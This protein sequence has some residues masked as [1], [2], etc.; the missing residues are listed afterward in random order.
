VSVIIAGEVETSNSRL[1]SHEW[2]KRVYRGLEVGLSSVTRLNRFR[3]LCG[4]DGYPNLLEP[5]AFPFAL[6]AGR[7]GG[8]AEQKG[9]W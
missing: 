9:G 6:I 2:S 1:D 3:F 8:V 4:E 5:V 7:Y